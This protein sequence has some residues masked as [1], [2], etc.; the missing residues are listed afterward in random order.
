M[1]NLTTPGCAHPSA[2][3]ELTHRPMGGAKWNM[4]LLTG[5][6]RGVA[7]RNDNGVEVPDFKLCILITFVIANDIEPRAIKHIVIA[8]VAKQSSQ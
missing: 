8:S 4:R 7:P 3:G 2:G 6:P 5:L 1:D